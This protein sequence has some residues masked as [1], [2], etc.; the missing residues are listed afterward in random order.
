MLIRYILSSVCLRL[1]QFPQLSFMQYTGLCVLSLPIFVMIV[2]IGVLYLIIIIKSEVWN[3]YL[4]RA[5]SWNN[6]MHCMSFYVLILFWSESYFFTFRWASSNSWTTRWNDGSTHLM[7]WSS[8]NEINPVWTFTLIIK[9]HS[10]REQ[11]MLMKCLLKCIMTEC[12]ISITICPSQFEFLG[13]V[14]SLWY[15]S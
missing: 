11:W 8:R 3:I 5:R 12:E 15:D 7:E 9:I 13:N 2:R 6:A 1:S 14:F 10:V 4:F